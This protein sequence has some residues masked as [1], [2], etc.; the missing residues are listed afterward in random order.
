MIPN[1]IPARPEA[2]VSQ[3]TQPDDVLTVVAFDED[4]GQRDVNVHG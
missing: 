4:T 1:A 2:T 3:F